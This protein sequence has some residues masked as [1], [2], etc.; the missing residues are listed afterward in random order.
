MTYVSGLNY[1]TYTNTLTAMTIIVSSD[2]NF[3]TV[4]PSAI[5][6]AEQRIYREA[7]FLNSVN[8][9]VGTLSSNA[10]N[11]LY[12]TNIGT[13]LIIEQ[14]FVEDATSSGLFYPL[15]ISSIDFMQTVY[16]SFNTSI[17]RP[18]YWAPFNDV[19]FNVAP[20]PDQAYNFQAIGTQR[21]PALSASNSSTF[22]TQVLP[23]LFVAASMIYMTAY[24][25]NWGA[26]ADD[27]RSALSWESQ[28]QTL[29]KS[30]I[31]EEFRKKYESGAWQPYTPTPA[32]PRRV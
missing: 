8:T 5:N 7:D 2:V 10:R 31:T 3:Q 25:K 1:T 17:G 15:Q 32:T 20:V 21:P 28:Y 22:L 16:P 24:M 26:Q 9:D 27:P 12:P 13:F 23:D 14:M 18:Q 19:S 29:F 11:F 6:Y 30:A 4:L